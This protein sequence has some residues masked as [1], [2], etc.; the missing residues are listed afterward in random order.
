M[1]TTQ[2]NNLIAVRSALSAISAGV[3]ASLVCCIVFT[4]ARIAGITSYNEEF[5]VSKAWV[6]S[7]SQN[8]AIWLL[9]LIVSLII[10]GIVGWLYSVGFKAIRK[11]ARSGWDTGIALGVVHWM[12]AG[13]FIGYFASAGQPGYFGVALGWPTFALFFLTHLLFGAIVGGLY[14]PPARAIDQSGI[15]SEHEADEEEWMREAS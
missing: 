15:I 6:G 4:A 11:W 9:G 7:L 3:I 12:I 5:L 1:K 8:P 2:S 14:L 10:G 13:L